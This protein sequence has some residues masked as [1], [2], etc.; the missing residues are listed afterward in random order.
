[1]HMGIDNNVVALLYRRVFASCRVVA[2]CR[3]FV[4]CCVLSYQCVVASLQRHRQQRNTL[5]QE[6]MRMNSRIANPE[7]MMSPLETDKSTILS[8]L[9]AAYTA[10]ACELTP[11]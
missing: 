1:M 7:T 9:F 11:T 3:V 10:K 8:F 5:C 2:S 6:R 4:L